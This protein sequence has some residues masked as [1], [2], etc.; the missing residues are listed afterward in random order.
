MLT[1][2]CRLVKSCKRTESHNNKDIPFCELLIKIRPSCSHLLI[3]VI[4]KTLSIS[5]P[6]RIA[7]LSPSMKL[8]FLFFR[9]AIDA[10]SRK[11]NSS[12]PNNLSFQPITGM[13]IIQ[14]S[15]FQICRKVLQF[16]KHPSLFSISFIFTGKDTNHSCVNI[17]K[18]Y[19]YFR[20][21]N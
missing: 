3:Y 16:A 8:Q 17:S 5:A 2:T 10:S 12:F 4:G 18:S 13:P 19:G 1:L 9:K 6:S 21:C 20:I 14:G 15:T 11:G 7:Y